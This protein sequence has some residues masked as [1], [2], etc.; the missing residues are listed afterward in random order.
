MTLSLSVKP[1]S[2]RD[3]SEKVGKRDILVSSKMSISLKCLFV[4]EKFWGYFEEKC[5]MKSN[6]N[7]YCFGIDGFNLSHSKIPSRQYF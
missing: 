4:F 5:E 1:T 6:Y 7:T 3:I 2:E